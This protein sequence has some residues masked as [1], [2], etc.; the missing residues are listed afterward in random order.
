MI[1]KDQ[2]RK[3][4]EQIKKIVAAL[5]EDS[6]VSKAFEGCF[7]LAEEN[8]DN[9]FWMSWKETAE[10][11]KQEAEKWMDKAE[12]LAKELDITKK[13][14]AEVEE[15][16]LSLDDLDT[17]KSVVYNV[18]VEE[19]DTVKQEADSIVELADQPQTELFRKT[20]SRHRMA[21]S[22]VQRYEE[23]LYSINKAMCV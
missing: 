6:Y 23:L 16:S 7:G 3:A 22:K 20:V 15:K 11:N 14:L 4:L 18:K 12:E 5:G 21:V 2:E 19:Q 1:T 8:I 13:R 10:L 17:L 9:D